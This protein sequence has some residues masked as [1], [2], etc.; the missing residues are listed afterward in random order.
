VGPTTTTNSS[1]AFFIASRLQQQ[2]QQLAQHTA[3]ADNC[4]FLNLSIDP[5]TEVTPGGPDSPGAS[6]TAAEGNGPSDAAAAAAAADDGHF[7]MDHDI[8]EGSVHGHEGTSDAASVGGGDAAGPGLIRG[9]SLV[10][11]ASGSVAGDG[12][13]SSCSSQAPVV[14]LAAAA[15]GVAGGVG[16]LAQLQPLIPV[17]ISGEPSG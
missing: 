10:S 5:S 12:A 11:D 3:T 1:E 17:S 6:G 16:Q 15:A 8:E 7:G 13:A 14:P 4:P 2:D 9:A